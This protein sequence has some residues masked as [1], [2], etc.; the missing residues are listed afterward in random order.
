[1]KKL[2]IILSFLLPFSV[3]AFSFS[4]LNFQKDAPA[5]TLGD[6]LRIL[7]VPQG[8][9]GAAT[10]SGCLE[11]NGTAAITGTGSPCGSGGGGSSFSTTSV[12]YYLSQF[13]DWSVQ[14]NG[15][16]A[17]T[18]TRGIVV[19]ASS[20]IGAGASN[21][22]LTIYGNS[23]TTGSAY[24][25]DKLGVGTN[26]P[27]EKFVVTDSAAVRG[28][29]SSTGSFTALRVDSTNDTAVIDFS[30]GGVNKWGIG[31]NG[32]S[33]DL[34]IYDATLGNSPIISAVNGNRMVGIGT[35]T[36]FRTLGVGGGAYIGGN[37]TATGTIQF[38][39]ITGSTQCL[40][41]D[42]TGLVTGTGSDC[43][44]G[45]AGNWATSS[46]DYYNS[47]F[48]DWQIVNGA[49]SPTTTKGIVLAASSTISALTVTNA[50][51]TFATTTTLYV[52]SGGITTTGSTTLQNF[53]AKNSTSTNATTTTLYS[54]TLGINSEYFTDLTG[55]GLSNVAGAL[56][57]AGVTSIVAGQN[58]AISGATGA[59]TVNSVAPTT[60]LDYYAS[61]FRDWKLDASL[62]LVPTTT[63]PI[64]VNAA[65]STITNF[66][67]FNATNTNATST[68]EYVSG[69]FWLNAERFTDLTGTGLSNT[70][71]LLT[72]A[73][74]TS[75]VAGQNVAISGAT[76]AVTVNSVAPTTTLDYYTSLFRD[77]SLQGS[78][79]YLAPTTSRAILV[80]NG[81]STITNLQV[82]NGTT[83]NA[84][85][86]NMNISGKYVQG[87]TTPLRLFNVYGAQAGG[88]AQFT[89]NAGNNPA[90]AIYGTQD[91]EV[92]GQG[93]I[94]AQFGPAQTF[95][96]NGNL[97]ADMSAYYD[98]NLTNGILQFRTYLAGNPILWGMYLTSAGN[99][100]IGTSTPSWTLDV[101][102]TSPF[103][104]LTDTSAASG[105]K[106]VFMQNNDGILN[107]GTSSDSLNSTSSLASLDG[108]GSGL[109]V[110][111]STPESSSLSFITADFS[112][113]TYAFKL[114]HN[115]S[116]TP[117]LVVLGTNGDGKVG[118]GSTTPTERL[119]IGGN[120]LVAGN[121]TTTNFYVSNQQV[122]LSSTFPGVVSGL[123][124]LSF[125]TGTTT[126]WTSTTS[127]A[128][129]SKAVAPFAGTIRNARCATDA[130]FLNV[131]FYHTATHLTLL[132]GASSTVGTVPFSSNNTF[133]AGEVLYM[134]AGT[135][136][137]SLATSLACTLQITETP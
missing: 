31:L 74:V 121:S 42:T 47:Q 136:T 78:P 96:A 108:N 35:T 75:I 22:G 12:N 84:T 88:I 67:S 65:S 43:G 57:N 97:L 71:G 94:P 129:I 115:G 104:T 29:F 25:V 51:S 134:S 111:T 116:S 137:T 91:I 82:V 112:T 131:D 90:S 15:Y 54:S 122:N 55:T 92:T 69:S 7:T 19:N 103:L 70:A 101:A 10:L 99:V 81:T 60:T 26:A 23:T 56:T 66:N 41:V 95:T 130:G 49:L 11:G 62:N 93:T 1:M 98:G 46:S 52:N 18:T 86:T 39:N 87:T 32:S 16:L 133:T 109:A 13:R 5:N 48:R 9:T 118:L 135:T 80:N 40:H 33:N 113:P 59:V 79:I 30:H 53:T 36:P 61:L 110:G 34:S 45:A 105:Y 8:G 58:V 77:W 128:Y 117:A 89:R 120:L 17:P 28:L 127:G 68:N 37:F 76:G 3:S 6:A 132:L 107:F 73:G 14:G 114:Q 124:N 20:T 100:G 63:R 85:S 24:I 83:T 119:S 125:Q 50:T 21:S 44:A 106:H 72:N 123:K 38:S 4:F 102:S 126:T 27:S 2:L 64:L